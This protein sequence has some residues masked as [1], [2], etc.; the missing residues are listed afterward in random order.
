MQALCVCG[1]LSRQELE[2]HLALKLRVERQ[3]DFAHS[4][5]ANARLDLIAPQTFS[6]FDTHSC[7]NT[8]LNYLTKEDCEQFTEMSRTSK[9]PASTSCAILIRPSNQSAKHTRF[10]RE[11]LRFL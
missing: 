9:G 2:R 7:C 6:D 1:H 3:I 10:R 8:W 11:C 4:A 5:R